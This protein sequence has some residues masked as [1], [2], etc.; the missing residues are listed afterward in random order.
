M[1][2]SCRPWSR[3][4]RE[5]LHSVRPEVTDR[6][7]P[8]PGARLGSPAVACV[9]AVDAGTTGVRAL[10]VDESG[11]SLDV[12]YRELTQ[13]FPRPGWVEHDP[14]RDLGR[15]CAATVAEVAARRLTGPARR[16][17]P[18]AS[19][20]SARP[21]WPGTAPPAGPCTA[22]SCGRTAAPPSRCDALA[23][24]PVTSRSSGTAR[25]SS[26]TRTS[27]PPRWSGC[28]SDGGVAERATASPSGTV[29]A[30]LLWNLTGG[31]DGGVFATDATNASPHPALRHRRPRL[32]RRAVRPL[33][34]A[35]VGPPRG[36]PLVRALRHRG[37]ATLGGRLAAGRR[38]RERGG[39]RPAGRPLR[40]GLLRPRGWPRSPTAPAASS[41]PTSV[42]RSRRRPRACSPRWPGTS[43][44]PRR[45]GHRWPTR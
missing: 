42:P 26:S 31:T 11:P 5:G 35:R 19:P 9:I 28:S 45:R 24:R 44:E 16:W 18:S 43:G 33:R 38:P 23:P 39:R 36:P 6:A 10:A 12:A 29:D 17:P 15:P 8:R 13:H 7:R 25:A 27:R 41:W 34:G 22:P 1:I 4:V 40:P 21:S 2:R 14:D 37:A 30:W 3:A 32:V 20:T